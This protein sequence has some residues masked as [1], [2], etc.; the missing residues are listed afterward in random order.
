VRVRGAPKWTAFCHC[1]SCRRQTGAPVSA[2]AGYERDQVEIQGGSFTR[3]A[4]SPGVSR[5][6]CRTCGSPVSYE[7]ERW[8]SE[9]HFHVGVFDDPD[10]FAPTGHVNAGEQLSWLC[11]S[12]RA[13][14]AG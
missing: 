3:Y 5:G 9:V 13:E 7:G 4:S 2:Y 11:V 6:F 12:S 8:P 10:P 1:A 14:T